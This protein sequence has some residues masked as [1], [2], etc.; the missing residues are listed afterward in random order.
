MENHCCGRSCADIYSSAFAIQAGKIG[1]TH[2]DLRDAI[3][4]FEIDDA[5]LREIEGLLEG[6]HG[7]GGIS[8]KHAIGV[9]DARNGGE[10]NTDAI[11]EILHTLHVRAAIASCE[12]SAGEGGGDA[13]GGCGG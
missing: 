10:I 9:F 11:E 4:R 7:G 13:C 6:T 8:A 2:I 5:S 3:P 12:I 1:D